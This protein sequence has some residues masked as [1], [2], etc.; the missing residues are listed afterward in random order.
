MGESEAVAPSDKALP[1]AGI[2][3]FGGIGDCCGEEVSGVFQDIEKLWRRSLG[4]FLEQRHP[5]TDRLGLRSVT[6]GPKGS[7]C[8]ARTSEMPTTM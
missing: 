5:G 7:V 2:Y 8:D 6:D 3:L 4:C 1:A